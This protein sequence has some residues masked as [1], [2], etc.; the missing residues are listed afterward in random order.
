MATKPKDAMLSLDI[1]AWIVENRDKIEGGFIK[2]IYQVGEREFLLKIYK[3]KTRSLY[4][5]LGGFLFFDERETPE[6]P[7]MFVMYLRKRFNNRKILRFQQINFD[8]IVIFDVGDYSLIFELFGGGNVIVVKDGV[9]E[10]AYVEREWRHRSILRGYEYVPPPGGHNP[11]LEIESL[12]DN[13]YDSGRDLVRFLAS[14][15]NLGR[16]AEEV[17]YRAS[18]DK[19]KRE[20]DDEEC[21][22]V[23]NAVKS[24]FDFD[25]CYL[26]SDFFSPVRLMHRSDDFKKFDDMNE[27]LRE[28][29]SKFQRMGTED[30]KLLAIKEMQRK[31][32]EEFK[33]EEEINRK[34]GDTIYAHFQ[35]IE[36]LLNRARRGEIK[37]TNKRITVNFDGIEFYLHV[38]K[39]PG[40]NATLYYER[41]KKAREKIKGAMKA[42]AEIEER[43]KKEAREKKKKE[44]R[45]S[46]RRFWFEKYRWFLSSEGHVV[47]AG[48]DAKTN[49][50]V[51]KKHLGDRDLYMHADI[52]GAPSVVIKADGRDIGEKTLQE[53]AQ[54]AV[55][56][57]KAWNA[58][59][60]NLSAYWVYPSQ[61]SKM[62]ESGEYVAKGAWVIHGKRNYIHKVPLRLAVGKINYQ[63]VDLVMCGPVDAVRAYTDKY[64]I[65]E[66]GEEKKERVA[67]KLSEIYGVP[68]EEL[69]HILPPGKI[70]IVNL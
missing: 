62:G 10:R 52:H 34:I 8:R 43:I 15:Y 3:G 70:K 4:I 53:A 33:R 22:R 27:C 25:G 51:V 36:A 12:C 64:V 56:M 67:R 49:E 29:L 32:I 6:T 57:S 46:R 50:E 45:K 1:N 7:S 58:G 2:K 42:I 38:D 44:K 61:V 13:L 21:E 41:A 60:G 31:K 28:Y 59:L 26:Y 20:L 65:I 39:S 40:E 30:P 54:F 23:K 11:L 55:S 47:I 19:N 48:K 37:V 14:E 69:L 5:S 68:V 66:P 18:V 24:I 35:E 63:G 9:I 16:Y 17:C